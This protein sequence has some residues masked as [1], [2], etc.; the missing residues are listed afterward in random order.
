MFHYI[1]SDRSFGC[2]FEDFV[3]LTISYN[4]KPAIAIWTSIT[5]SHILSRVNFTD[6][7]KGHEKENI[8]ISHG[9]GRWFEDHYRSTIAG[10][11]KNISKNKNKD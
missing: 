10:S 11:S 2:F 8:R 9:H 4:T 3:N 6:V 5:C 7:T 1:Q